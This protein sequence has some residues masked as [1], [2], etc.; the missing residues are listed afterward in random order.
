MKASVSVQVSTQLRNG[1]NVIH[2][3]D[4]HNSSVARTLVAMQSHDL[5]LHLEQDEVERWIRWL[6]HKLHHANE[7]L[8]QAE[9]AY[10]AR[11][12][13]EQPLITAR[14]D[15]YAQL[16]DDIRSVRNSIE[17]IL[18]RKALAR[19]GMH[20]QPPQRL[21]DL[22]RYVENVIH[23][24][25]KNPTATSR[26]GISMDTASIAAS[27]NDKRQHYNQARQDEKRN[28]RDIEDAKGLRDQAVERWRVV[29]L[30]VAG[31]LEHL[32]RLAERPDLAERV[33]PTLRR[34]R[35]EEGPEPDAGIPPAN[36][37][38]DI[39]ELGPSQPAPEEPFATDPA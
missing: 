25:G 32:F 37:Q 18:G 34:A 1:Q 10:T 35:G 13:T 11:Q 23:L 14:D 2:A 17:Q 3:L 20:K 38:P 26:L 9:L 16:N 15:A 22:E 4:A 28:R 31:Q 33:R 36:F 19:F 21:D 7:S 5:Q 27:L 24:L 12:G 39:L 29:Y 30:A 6:R 8:N